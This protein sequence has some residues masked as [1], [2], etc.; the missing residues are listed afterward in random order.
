MISAVSLF[1]MHR[2]EQR[3]HRPHGEPRAN[4]LQDRQRCRLYPKVQGQFLK[5]LHPYLGLSRYG[6]YVS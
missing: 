6:D 1:M 4:R 2:G 3:Y 5:R